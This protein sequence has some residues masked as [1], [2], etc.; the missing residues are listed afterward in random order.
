LEGSATKK[1]TDQTA[2]E[3]KTGLEETGH[4]PERSGIAQRRCREEENAN[5][6]SQKNGIKKN[7]NP[8][9]LIPKN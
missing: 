3:T 5:G 2:R 4:V 6:L 1:E 8:D 9:R 7:K